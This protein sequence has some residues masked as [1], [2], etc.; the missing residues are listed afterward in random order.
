MIKQNLLIENIPAILWG[1]KSTKI[2]VAVHGNMSSKTDVPIAMLAE[3]AIPLGYQVLS[4]DL[5]QHGDRKE[6]ITLCKVQNCVQ[7]LSTIM[8]FAIGHSN[9]IS[10]LACSIGAYFSLLA[11]RDVSLRRSLFLSPIVDMS[12]IIDNMMTWFNVSKERLQ[13][14]QEIQ[15]S[16]GH[17]LYWDYYCYVKENPVVYWKSPTAILYGREDNVCEFETISSFA[18]RFACS[19]DVMENGEHYFYTPEQLKFYREWLKEKLR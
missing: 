10:L 9:H 5:P 17:A 3:E 8:D 16:L 7:D 12:R 4:F 14:E 19:L 15:T 2:M 13:A 11:Y 18:T 1:E 6:E